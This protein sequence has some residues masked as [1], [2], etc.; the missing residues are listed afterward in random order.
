MFLVADGL[1]TL[2]RQRFVE[3]AAT[4]RIP[5]MYEW[6]SIVWEGGVM[7]YGPGMDD[8]LHQAAGYIDRIL[9]MALARGLRCP[10]LAGPAAWAGLGEPRVS[11]RSARRD[12]TVIPEGRRYE[13]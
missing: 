4:H 12:S 7:S 8:S 10:E 6:N 1:T 9:H 2:N 3:F 11:R 13:R 5:T